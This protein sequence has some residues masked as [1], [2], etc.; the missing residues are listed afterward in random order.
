MT[1]IYKSRDE[2]LHGGILTKYFVSSKVVIL[3]LLL[4]PEQSRYVVNMYYV[5][6]ESQLL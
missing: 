2:E 3:F 5:K 6:D 1:E 4:G